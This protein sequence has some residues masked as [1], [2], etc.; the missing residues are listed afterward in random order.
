M[1]FYLFIFNKS[2]V[3]QCITLDLKGNSLLLQEPSWGRAVPLD[4]LAGMIPTV[5]HTTHEH[6]SENS[7]NFLLAH[8][9][10]TSKTSFH[11]QQISTKVLKGTSV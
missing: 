5:S 9:S 7:S 4:L 3:N 8:H 1:R 2:G 11:M 6:T 10:C